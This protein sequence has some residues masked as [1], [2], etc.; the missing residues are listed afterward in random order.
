M[1]LLKSFP[2]KPNQLI[3]NGVGIIEIGIGIQ[4]EIAIERT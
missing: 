1:P 4:I 3:K 2:G